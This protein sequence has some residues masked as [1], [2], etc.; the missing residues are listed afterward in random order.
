MLFPCNQFLSQ[1]PK[2]PTK[3]LVKQLTSGSL[4]VDSGFGM[5]MSKV[6]VNGADA[7][8]VYEFLKYNS[9]L[10]SESTGKAAPIPWN[11][12]KF[13]INSK[14]GGVHSYFSP[15]SKLDDV[16]ADVDLLL[17]PSAPTSTTRGETQ[18]QA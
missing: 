4:D 15:K 5:L 17:S 13:L 12:A 16:I 2:Q 14:G 6:N 1:E 3:G 18:P 9:S 11:F 7:S 10:Y 8:P